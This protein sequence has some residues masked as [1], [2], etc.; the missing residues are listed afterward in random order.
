MIQRSKQ[1]RFTL[2]ARDAFRFG[3]EN[4]GKN[5]DRHIAFQRGIAGPIHFALAAGSNKLDDLIGP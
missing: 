1:F 4:R 3:R 2:K 5:L